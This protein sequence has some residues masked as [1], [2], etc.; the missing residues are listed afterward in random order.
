MNC[1]CYPGVCAEEKNV[2]GVHLIKYDYIQL[3]VN[4]NGKA[5]NPADKILLNYDQIWENRPCMCNLLLTDFITT[6]VC[7]PD[8][9]TE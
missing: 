6:L 8:T 2:T 3:L 5:A 9:I 1:D 7:Y 4:S